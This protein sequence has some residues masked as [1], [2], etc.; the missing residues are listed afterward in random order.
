[1]YA[2]RTSTSGACSSKSIAGFSA[3]PKPRS[4]ELLGALARS[5][6]NR[7]DTDLFVAE[8]DGAVAG[9]AALSLLPTVAGL[10]A[11]LFLA[12]TLPQARNQGVQTAL[13]AARTQAAHRRGARFAH[14][15]ARPG[16]TSARNV[17]R[18]GYRLAYTKLTLS[19]VQ[20][21]RG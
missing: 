4:R 13:L 6:C 8:L 11:H 14:I 20:L 21:A 12:S 9:T 7:A 15:T 1:L 3:Q 17:E 19:N 10:V 2:H 5:A 16:T 18:A